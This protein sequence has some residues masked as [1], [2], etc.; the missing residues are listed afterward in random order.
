MSCLKV[1]IE[2]C[3]LLS[4]VK[5]KQTNEIELEWPPQLRCYR[6]MEPLTEYHEA[7]HHDPSLEFGCQSCDY[8]A[9]SDEKIREHHKR[10]HDDMIQCPKCVM[11]VFSQWIKR[12]DRQCHS[13]GM[14]T[15]T[16][17]F[18]LIFQQ[19]PSPVWKQTEYSMVPD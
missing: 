13:P 3:F 1:G 6:C 19:C 18:L 14:A 17:L 2:S 8:R 12:H 4:F 5:N 15:L 10:I 11:R 16:I 7:E 9:D